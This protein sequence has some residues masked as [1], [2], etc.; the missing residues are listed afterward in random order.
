MHYIDLTSVSTVYNP[1]SPQGQW[2]FHRIG[3]RDYP[4]KELNIKYVKK[5]LQ[6][7]P[8]DQPVFLKSFYGDSLEYTKILEVVRYADQLGIQ[9]FIFTYGSSYDE[10]LLLELQKYNVRFYVTNYGI[11]ELSN[12]VVSNF[13]NDAFKKFLKITKRKTII[14]Y[15]VYQHNIKQV[16]D[17]I[18]LCVEFGTELK[19]TKGLVYE[20][21]IA[22]LIKHNGDWTGDI[23]EVS[24][25]LPNENQFLTARTQLLSCKNMFE[26]LYMQNNY[27]EIKRTVVGRRKLLRYIRKQNSNKNILKK[28]NLPQIEDFNQNVKEY[29]SSEDLIL[30]YLG[31]VFNNYTIYETFNNA[32]CY[33]WYND[34]LEYYKEL[35][36][37]IMTY[38][39][40]K[41]DEYFDRLSGILHRLSMTDYNL[42]DIKKQN[43]VDIKTNL[44]SCFGYRYI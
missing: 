6:S 44:L 29:K 37:S 18:D 24:N 32:I 30:S 36:N 26:D 12:T 25:D 39:V 1:I 43:I 2:I 4:I 11:D 23:F 7:M 13:D 31:Y 9:S 14:E 27:A 5:F 3:Q 16:P 35:N 34:Y 20:D 19:I 10:K 38:K 8:S 40:Y 21:G 28:I 41:R 22:N 33:D 15:Q 17:I 42:I